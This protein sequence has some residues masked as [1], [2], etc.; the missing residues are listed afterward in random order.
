MKPLTDL[1]PLG[2]ARP[3][4]PYRLSPRTRREAACLAPPRPR[5]AR[6]LLQPGGGG[7][8]ARV[9]AGLRPEGFE[10]AGAGVARPARADRVVALRQ[11]STRLPFHDRTVRLDIARQ[12]LP[13]DDPILGLD[14]A[15]AVALADVL[16][17]AGRLGAVVGGPDDFKPL[18]IEGSYLSTQKMRALEERFVGALHRLIGRVDG[19][20]PAEKHIAAALRDVVRRVPVRD[21]IPLPLS[22]D[23]EVAVKAAARHPLALIS[24]GPGTGKTTIIVAILR[25]LHR[26]GVPCEAMLLAVP[27]GKAA[28][29]MDQAVRTGL[30]EIADPSAADL[31]LEQLPEAQTLHRLLGYSPSSGQS[32]TTRTTGSPGRLSWWTRPR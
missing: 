14:A 6:G 1:S 20:Q 3:P 29:R 19:I 9:G 22:P 30:A 32:C 26:L 18:V 21:G 24:G 11:G 23:Q 12:L 4:S 27:T 31:A 15:R 2:T 25:V 13:G 28:Q 10:P 8:P 17:E 16:I 7:R 5:A